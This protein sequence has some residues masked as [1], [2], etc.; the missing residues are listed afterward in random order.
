[1]GKPLFDVTRFDIEQEIM[2]IGSFVNI[3]KQYANAIYDGQYVSTSEDDIHTT[4][5]GFANLLDSHLDRMMES[6][7]KHYR[8][9]QYSENVF[10]DK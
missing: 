9:N 7:C 8:L 6:H 2:E 4:L 10:D 5:H 3:L 1:M